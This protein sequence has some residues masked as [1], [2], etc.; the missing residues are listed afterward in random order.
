M[1]LPRKLR[2]GIGI[3]ICH[4]ALFSGSEVKADFFTVVNNGP[5]SNRVD[6]V[7]VGDGY[8]SGEI[9]SKYASDV[10]SMVSYMFGGTQAPFPRYSSFFNVHRVNVISMRNLGRTFLS[11]VFSRT[12][13]STRRI[14]GMAVTDRLLYLNTTKANNAVSAA[15]VNSGIDVDMRIGVVN[16]TVYGGAGGEWAVYAGS[17]SSARE[18][19]VHEIGHSFA[20]L[21]DEYFFPGTYTGPEPTQPNLTTSPATGKWDRWVGYNDPNSNI[22]PIGYYKGGGYNENG[23]YRPSDDSKMR[24]LDRPFDAVSREAFIKSIYAEVDPLDKWL[25]T[26]NVLHEGDSAW[27]D[28]IDPNVIKVNWLLD[29]QLL[30]IHDE[31]LQLNQ[32]GLT[33][34]NHTLTALAYDS[35]LDHA[36]T[37]DSLDW[38]RLSQSELQQSVTWQVAIT[39]VPEPS[40]LGLVAFVATTFGF[41]CRRRAGKA[42]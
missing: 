25:T 38:W 23:L 3:G 39:A 29:G 31:T 42:V 32:L 11:R 2:V 35:I 40:T 6:T 20:G 34:G 9:E 15:L 33:V 7:F 14:D 16:E 26:T 21:A 24:S 17:N 19:A 41:Y 18:I 4:L 13:R 10:L 30:A 28:S 37:G 1:A 12:P 36:F 27:V 8:T 22:G 5:S